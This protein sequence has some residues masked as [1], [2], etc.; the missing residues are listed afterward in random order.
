MNEQAREVV[1]ILLLHQ[2]QATNRIESAQTI[3]ADEVQLN[4]DETDVCIMASA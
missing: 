4:E 1:R 3:D 2:H